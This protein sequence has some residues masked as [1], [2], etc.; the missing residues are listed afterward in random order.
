MRRRLAGRLGRTINRP[1]LIGEQAGA[2]LS[3]V[4]GG[5]DEK[6][7]YGALHCARSF[8][9]VRDSAFVALVA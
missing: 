6:A 7:Y 3:N 9:A 8:R 1:N 2:V 5:N 4:Q